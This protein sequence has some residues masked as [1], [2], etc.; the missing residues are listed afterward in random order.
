MKFKVLIRFLKIRDKNIIKASN[1]ESG[2]IYPIA[3]P[4]YSRTI[5]D[6]SYRPSR[7]MIFDMPMSQS[8][9]SNSS[10]FSVNMHYQY[11]HKHR[12]SRFRRV[13]R[14]VAKPFVKTAHFFAMLSC[15]SLKQHPVSPSLGSLPSLP[16]LDI[17]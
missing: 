5:N 6:Y 17:D 3:P 12:R 9:F 7:E 13:M 15:L 2:C 4:S 16:S 8:T 14:G 11:H 10:E 1:M